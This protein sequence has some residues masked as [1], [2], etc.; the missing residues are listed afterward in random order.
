[1]PSRNIKINDVNNC[2]KQYS[3]QDK[4]QDEFHSRKMKCELEGQ[5]EEMIDRKYKRKTKRD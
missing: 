5:T 2:S 3:Q 1:M 4:W